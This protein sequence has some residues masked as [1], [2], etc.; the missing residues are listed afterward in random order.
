MGDR[1]TGDRTGAEESSVRRLDAGP[2]GPAGAGAS[3]ETPLTFKG[4]SMADSKTPSPPTRPDMP[5]RVVDIPGAPSIPGR[6]RPGEATAQAAPSGQPAA[7]SAPAGTAATTERKLIVGRE[8]S[9]NGEINACDHLVVEGRV[10]AKLADCKTIE[11][12]EG[13]TFKGSAEID[14]ATIGGRF[15]GDLIVRGR[16][17][18]TSGGVISGTVHYGELEVAAGGR[19]IGSMEPLES[20]VTPLVDPKE[21]AGRESAAGPETGG[22]GRDSRDMAPAGGYDEAD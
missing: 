7:G 22:E 19:L 13:G 21:R 20:T 14:E 11:V 15:E 5:R 10:E 1:T 2:A 3:D 16:L 18:L 6:S 17:R 4:R 8:I 12:A 9:L